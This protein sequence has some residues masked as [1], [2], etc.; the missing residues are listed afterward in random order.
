[1]YKPIPKI[2]IVG[3]E[4]IHYSVC[5]GNHADVLHGSREFENSKTC[6][7]MHGT[8]YCRYSHNYERDTIHVTNKSCGSFLHPSE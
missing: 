6:A 4:S 5:A 8:N 3:K 1:M 7:C 2:V